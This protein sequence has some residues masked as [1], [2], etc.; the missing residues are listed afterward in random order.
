M[1]EKFILRCQ[2]RI[3][4]LHYK[5]GL[6]SFTVAVQIDRIDPCYGERRR[7]MHTKMSV[8]SVSAIGILVAM[9]VILARF[10]IHTWN[11]KLGFSF[12]PIVVAAI[13][14]GSITAG[15]VAA[16]GDIVSAIL[17]PVGAYF[18]G[19]TLTAFLTGAVFGWM[20]RKKVT[21]W[22]VILSVIVVQWL[23][24]QCLN[25]YWISFLYGSPYWPLFMTRVYQTAVMSA[26]Q[27]AGI[28]MIAKKLVPILK[29]F[30]G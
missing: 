9:E 3:P 25:T 11:L 15:L 17:F 12:V 21:V 24:S 5:G 26:V 4:L 19:F 18:P 14:Y 22:N 23:I 16:I 13:F 8:K 28:W 30:E 2:I 1:N 6:P 7:A 29:K 20:F 10:S 27:V